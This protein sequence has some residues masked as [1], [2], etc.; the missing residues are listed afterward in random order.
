MKLFKLLS[1]ATL[2][3]F[4]LLLSA[5]SFARVTLP[6]IDSSI[7]KSLPI[8]SN[9]PLI[10]CGE[11]G[12]KLQAYNDMARQH[13]QSVATF[14]SEVVR[15]VSSWYDLLSPLE[16]ATQT[17]E[18]GTF[19]PLKDGSDKIASVADLAFENSSLLAA[20]MDRIMSSLAACTL[21]P[22]LKK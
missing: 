3:T 1:L 2:V 13:D 6:E 16:G 20:E 21:T 7:E 19:G 15:K 4:S 18:S 22:S 11:I 17:I 14:L 5:T 9:D 12:T 8:N 10:P